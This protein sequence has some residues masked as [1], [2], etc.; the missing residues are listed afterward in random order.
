MANTIEFLFLLILFELDK[1]SEIIDINDI[2]NEEQDKIVEPNSAKTFSI[3]Y[4]SEKTSFIIDNLEDEESNLQINI[5]SIDCNIEIYPKEEIKKQTYLNLYS[6]IVNST[7]NEIYIKPLKDI[8]EGQDK[9]NYENKSCFLTINSYYISNGKLNLEN[10]ESNYLYFG[11]EINKDLFKIFYEK[12]NIGKDSF[13]SINF[14]IQSPLSIDIYCYDNKKQEKNKI[15]KYINDST[16]IY[17]DSDFLMEKN[18]PGDDISLLIHIKNIKENSII[19][20]QIIED[21]NICLLAKN[22]LNFGFF[23]SKI[24]N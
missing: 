4:K 5:N 24:T 2:T 9:E 11:P 12:N 10:K 19:Y 15:S 1:S 23:T 22:K 7:I 21:N 20:F 6:L 8:E 16:F 3:N 18:N 14:I 13:V 17:L